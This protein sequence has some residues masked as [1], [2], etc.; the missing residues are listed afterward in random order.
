[1]PL[2]KEISSVSDIIINGS[3]I[4]YYSRKYSEKLQ[5]INS[6]NLPFHL[7]A[8]EILKDYVKQ[9]KSEA[10]VMFDLYSL[11]KTTIEVRLSIDEDDAKALLESEY[12]YLVKEFTNNPISST[13]VDILDEDFKS[14]D[15]RMYL[16]VGLMKQIMVM[17]IDFQDIHNNSTLNQAKGN[18]KNECIRTFFKFIDALDLDQ[19]SKIVIR[20][21][22]AQAIKLT[23]KVYLKNYTKEAE[24]L[25]QKSIVGPIVAA[26]NLTSNNYITNFKFLLECI[27]HPDSDEIMKKIAEISLREDKYDK[28]MN[29]QSKFFDSIEKNDFYKWFENHKA[30]NLGLYVYNTLNQFKPQFFHE[31][32]E[33]LKLARKNLSENL[34]V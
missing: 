2:D 27:I 15:I 30:E 21:L 23:D 5:K 18:Y 29:F 24:L 3:R 19:S 13:Q 31:W 26:A 28:W 34:G 22:T 11:R 33:G 16:P 4:E 1:M 14:I 32:Q 8:R 25:A 6:S 7:K 10:T 17:A 9:E 12:R 20:N